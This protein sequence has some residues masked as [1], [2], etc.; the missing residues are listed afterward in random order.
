[1]T[2]YTFRIAESF[3]IQ[4]IP[5]ARLAEY[6]AELAR[7][8]GE[9]EHVHLEEVVDG[10]VS[11]RAEVDAP[12]IPAVSARV[13]AVREGR[14]PEDATKA[15][16]RL[17]DM[18]ANDNAVG[19]L[20]D[21]SNAE[22]I[23]FP[24]KNRPQPAI[25]GPFREEGTLEGEIVRI[26]GKDETIHVTLRDGSVLYSRCVAT[27]E[28]AR[29]MA[30]Y[31]LGPIV[32][33]RGVGTWERLGNGTWELKS[34][35]INDFDVLDDMPLVEAVAKLRAVPGNDWHKEDAPV[36][37]VLNERGGSGPH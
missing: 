28:V 27:K 8:L 3:T 12:S 29:L 21:A 10:S 15:M 17:D 4:T 7:L 19:Q 2:T 32:R 13:L 6:M 36:E 31:I 20:L 24:G 18:L 11:L 16:Q 1:M 23:P 35:R 14:G 26:G 22:I 34:F 30:P 5:M 37:I 25:Y 33:V 9:Q